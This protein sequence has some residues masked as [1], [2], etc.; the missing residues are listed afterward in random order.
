MLSGI[1]PRK[2]LVASGIAVVH[3]LPGV[4]HNL[5]DHID[6]LSVV[7]APHL[8]ASLGLSVHGVGA[9]LKGIGQWRQQRTGLLTTNFGES[10]GFIKSQADERSPD[11]GLHFVIGKLANHGRTTLWGHGYSAHVCLLRPHS[12]GR[13]TLE[14]KDPMAAPVVDPNFLGERDDLE[15]LVRGFKLMRGILG[16]PA[17]TRL[18]G[19]EAPASAGAINDFQIEHYIRDNADTLYHPVGSCRMGKGD[20]DVVDPTLRVHGMQGLRVVDASIMPRIVSGN[21][22]A[23]TIMIGEKAADMIRAANSI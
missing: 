20:M 23:P 13:V 21:T 17:L 18:G 22:N 15:R 14:S 10:G 6:I 11:L 1:G 19:T 9:V 16:Q 12:R 7:N 2:H 5:H 4:G 8:T 3:D